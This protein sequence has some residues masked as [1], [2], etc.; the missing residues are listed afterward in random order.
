[1][2]NSVIK[3][4]SHIIYDAT[5]VTYD[6]IEFFARRK[7]KKPIQT[8]VEYRYNVIGC[9]LFVIKLQYIVIGSIKF[10]SNINNKLLGK[11]KNRVFSTS[12]TVGNKQYYSLNSLECLGNSCFKLSNRVDNVL[13]N[14]NFI[15]NDNLNCLNTK[16][17]EFSNRLDINGIYRS[18]LELSREYLGNKKFEYSDSLNT[19][20][21]R[22]ITNLLVALDLL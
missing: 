15:L 5:N 17:F 21:T 7:V 8:P 14:K 13:G 3:Y 12:N 11:V 16:R 18:R 1:M 9:K 19:N 2:S 4:N 20:G 22:D 10:S 6:G